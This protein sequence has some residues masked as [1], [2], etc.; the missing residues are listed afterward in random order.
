MSAVPAND[1]RDAP[2]GGRAERV[3]PETLEAASARLIGASGGPLGRSAAQRFIDSARAQHIDLSRFWFVRH[4]RSKRIVASAL[5][6]KSAP[7]P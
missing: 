1:R 7:S 2:L 3:T 6:Q 4:H 5:I